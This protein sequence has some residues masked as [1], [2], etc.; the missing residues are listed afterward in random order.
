MGFNLSATRPFRQRVALFPLYAE[1][2]AV[3]PWR[4]KGLS[5]AVGVVTLAEHSGITLPL[6]ER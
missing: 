2:P 5:S 6:E 3:L 1:A 4:S